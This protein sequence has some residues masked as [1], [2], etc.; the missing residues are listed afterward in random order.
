MEEKL[1]DIASSTYD[2]RKPNP[3]RS[4][5]FPVTKTIPSE[6][7]L[8]GERRLF[9]FGCGNRSMTNALTESRDAV[10]D[11]APSTQ[12]ICHTASC[13]PH[14][15][16][17]QRPA[18]DDLV[19]RYEQLPVLLTLEVVEHLYYPRR[20][21]SGRYELLPP[22]VAAMLSTPYQCHLKN[23]VLSI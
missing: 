21:A 12:V 17:S 7:I 9:E 22:G 10:T 6:I 15:K 16:I 4:Y 18:Y 23:P 11:V 2:D 8:H 14:L 13:Y 3:S 5:L 19:P 1:L 20:F